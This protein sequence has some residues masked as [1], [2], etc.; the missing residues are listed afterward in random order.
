MDKESITC[1]SDKL[2]INSESCEV[3]FRQ[4]KHWLG[5]GKRLSLCLNV[6]IEVMC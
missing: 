3:G 6:H 4:E 5:L 1:R 2:Q